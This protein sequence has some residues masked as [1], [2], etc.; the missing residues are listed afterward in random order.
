M[1]KTPEKTTIE[2]LLAQYGDPPV[3]VEELDKENP[4]QLLLEYLKGMVLVDETTTHKATIDIYSS[5]KNLDEYEYAEYFSRLNPTIP[6]DSQ[7]ILNTAEQCKKILDELCPLGKMVLGF[8]FQIEKEKYIEDRLNWITPPEAENQIT[9]YGSSK[10]KRESNS[11]LSKKKWLAEIQEK[12]AYLIA[13]TATLINYFLI[14]PEFSLKEFK[15]LI[16]STLKET[17]LTL[18]T[19]INLTDVSKILEDISRIFLE[20]KLVDLNPSSYAPKALVSELQY[21]V[22]GSAITSGCKALRDPKKWT[23][24]HLGEASYEHTKADKSDSVI[25]H[26][27]RDWANGNEIKSIPYSEAEQILDKFGVYPALLHLILAVHF[28]RQSDPLSGTLRL[29]GTDLIKDLGLDKRTDLTKEEKLNKVLETVT[30]VRSLVIKTKWESIVKVK[31]GKKLVD[32]PVGFEIPPSMMWDLSPLK[33]TEKDLLIDLDIRVKAGAWLGH[34]FNK[35]GRELGKALY[36]FATLSR[37]ILDLDPYHEELA[38]RIALLQSTMDYRQYYTVEQWLIENLLG[39][40]E[41]I[42]KAKTNQTI[43][44]D[45]TNLWDNT[46]I[47]LE[48]IGFTIS[49]KDQTYPENLRPDSPKKPYKYFEPLLM[50]QVKLTPKTLGKSQP[51]I[52]VTPVKQ[53]TEKVYSGADLLE[54]RTALGIT[55]RM[56][57]KY[58]DVHS[59]YVSRI[60]KTQVL[61]KEKYNEILDAIKYVSKFKSKF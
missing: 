20:L 5:I 37:K 3:E 17:D 9:R 34:F 60:E 49:Y 44:R 46:L 6:E 43:R 36:N 58:L 51:V 55:Q 41:R 35:S 42:S 16:E 30:A 25:T 53:I 21:M 59:M 10:Y 32:T 24:N 54:K 38:L 61:T 29:K 15:K 19:A 8:E 31:K 39:A 26:F 1:R 23:G 14:K 18:V 2:K 13:K 33:I 48:R 47:A 45:L 11:T 28:Y 50:A 12:T 40:N 7:N 4:K 22:G 57:T 27:I 56:I 52:D